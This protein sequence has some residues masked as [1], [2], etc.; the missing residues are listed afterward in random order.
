MRAGKCF[1]LYTA[2][3]F[4]NELEENTVP[5][6]Q[7][8]NLG[9]THTHTHTQAH[10]RTASCASI[11]ATSRHWTCAPVCVC[12][13]VCVCVCVTLCVGN[14]VLMLKSLGIHDLMGFD[15]MDPPAAETLLRALESLYALGALNDKGELCV[16]VCRDAVY[17]SHSARQR[18]AQRGHACM[19]IY[20]LRVCLSTAGPAPPL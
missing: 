19:C 1:R 10:T 15:F 18:E 20:A 9:E 11:E 5:E 3:A 12:V 16:C 13:F 4:E 7:R 8:T 14:V 6:I 2:W 17:L